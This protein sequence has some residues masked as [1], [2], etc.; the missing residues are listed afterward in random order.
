MRSYLGQNNIYIWSDS[1]RL[2][3]KFCYQSTSLVQEIYS[4]NELCIFEK[5]MMYSDSST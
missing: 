4:Q 2:V 3:F 1:H 5:K